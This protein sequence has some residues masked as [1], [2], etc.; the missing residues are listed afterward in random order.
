MPTVDWN[1]KVWGGG[2][3][4]SKDGDE[5]DD[6][7]RY[8]GI[9]YDSWKDQ[10]RR[11]FIVPHVRPQS[12]ALEIGPGHGRWSVLI[13]P[14]VRHLQLVDLNPSCIDFCRT[15][16]INDHQNV[17]YHVNDGRTLG[18]LPDGWMDFVWSFDTFVH[19]DEPE[20]RSYAKELHRVMKAQA[21]GVIHHPGSATPEQRRNGCRSDLDGKKF[22]AILSEN[23][24][25]VI[26]QTGEWGVGCN[27]AL[28]GDLLTVF[29]RP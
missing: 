13:A 15:R 25:H 28:T 14:K 2:Y 9:P 27:M 17:N 16:L 4:W 26:R 10:L 29:A 18:M 7:A 23:G 20:V 8:C 12:E 5:W 21:I 11:T 3:A 1:R 24:L 19:I 6:S 22:S